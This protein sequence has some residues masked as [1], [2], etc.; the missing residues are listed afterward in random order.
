[1]SQLSRRAL[2]R[3]LGAT[4]VTTQSVTA[5]AARRSPCAVHQGRWASSDNKPNFKGQLL[6][7]MTAR[8]AREREEL[9]LAMLERQARKGN[10]FA[11]TMCKPDAQTN[12]ST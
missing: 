7:S 8:M 2:Q 1:M 4:A 12:H 10:N 6:E 9:R 3:G 5:R 11:V